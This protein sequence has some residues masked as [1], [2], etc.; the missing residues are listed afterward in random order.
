MITLTLKRRDNMKKHFIPFMVVSL[1]IAFVA[2]FI[3][4]SPSTAQAAEPKRGGWMKVA[5]DSTAVGLDP[6]HAIA[7]SSSTYY[8]HVNESLL[9][10]KRNMELEPALATSWEQP[11]PLTYI[12]HLRKGVKFHDGGDFTAE[13][14]KFT[15]DRILDP[16]TNSPRRPAFDSISKVEAL[17][18]FGTKIVAIE[19]RRRPLH[20]IIKALWPEITNLFQGREADPIHPPSCCANTSS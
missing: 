18:K 2:S 20:P 10:Y 1:V 8:E 12:F 17:D 5:T 6:A 9:R 11:D 16:K 15:F 7:F 4:T 19:G 13:D 14:V 3:V